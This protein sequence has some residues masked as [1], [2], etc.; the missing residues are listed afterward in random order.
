MSLDSTV[1]SAQVVDLL[2]ALEALGAD[3]SALAASVELP[4]PAP[5]DPHSRVP[6][7]F[8]VALLDAG[9]KA[10]ADPL[11]GL[12]AGVSNL[13]RGP[14]FFLLLSTP[15]VSEGLRLISRFASVSLST[16]KI[17][18]ATRGES[19][20][21]AI[22]PGDP[23]LNRSHHAVDYAVGAVLSFF[24]RAVAGF[25]LLGVELT[26]A[27]VGQQGETERILGCPVRFR[28]PRNL[29]RFPN[30]TLDAVPAAASPLIARQIEEFAESL[31]A[32]REAEDFA[33]RVADVVRRLLSSGAV[34][35]RSA[36]ASRMHVSVRTLQR[37]LGRDSLKLRDIRNRE[38]MELAQLLLSNPALSVKT[39]AESVGFADTAAFSKAFTR[40][41]GLTPTSYRLE[42]GAR[43]GHEMPMRLSGSVG[44]PARLRRGNRC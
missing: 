24:R 8:F 21:L 12:R 15:R 20:D 14:L 31:L 34:P 25:R 29:L 6:S 42:R 19:I 18:V 40:W 30:E 36:V 22:D 16:L 11:I 4:A 17:E 3:A 9:D 26:H 10:L 7:S 39:I 38:R 35:H 33:D 32:E 28:R 5:T 13:V 44:H 37:Q 43:S 23:V 2:A 41:A 1:G 27:E